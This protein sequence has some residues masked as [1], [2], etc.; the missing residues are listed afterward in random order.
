MED[1]P[2]AL[3]YMKEVI[4]IDMNEFKQCPTYSNFFIIFLEV[5][6]GELLTLELYSLPLKG[7]SMVDFH[8]AMRINNLDHHIYQLN[9]IE[10]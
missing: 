2:S 1:Y 3:E 7:L 10:N 6:H 9:T 8:F 4:K 5:E